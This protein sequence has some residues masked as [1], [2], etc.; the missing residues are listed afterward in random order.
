MPPVQIPKL[1]YSVPNTEIIFRMSASAILVLTITGASSVLGPRLSGLF[2]PFPIAGTVLAGFTHYY[3]GHEATVGLLKGFLR[4]L[5]GMA[6]FDYVLIALS[7][8]YGFLPAFV[9]AIFCALIVGVSIT[10]VCSA[11]WTPK[12][13]LRPVAAPETD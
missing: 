11:Y 6:A 4:G 1:S 9:V 2:A 5:V 13:I 3:Y 12:N 10:K 8:S 7:S